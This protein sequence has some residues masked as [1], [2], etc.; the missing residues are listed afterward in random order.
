MD[1]IS[2]MGITVHNNFGG[3]GFFL[4][5][6]ISILPV[7]VTL[8]EIVPR[9]VAAIYLR[10]FSKGFR[11]FVANIEAVHLLSWVSRGTLV[12]IGLSSSKFLAAETY[13]LV[14]FAGALV[15]ITLRYAEKGL[16]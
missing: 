6:G 1:A 15:V 8:N 9:V 11:G 10:L 7:Q 14:L 5:S 2:W 16:R 4:F 13:W 12:L 3:M